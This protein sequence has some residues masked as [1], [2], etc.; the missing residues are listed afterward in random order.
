MV[1]RTPFREINLIYS[2]H[3]PITH[4]ILSYKN[5]IKETTSM[6]STVEGP[7]TAFLNALGIDVYPDT[8]RTH[9]LSSQYD[10]AAVTTSEVIDQ[11]V[12]TDIRHT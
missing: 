12:L 7:R 9:F 1:P 4:F 10:N 3:L 2:L 8:T 11:I 6:D 5:L